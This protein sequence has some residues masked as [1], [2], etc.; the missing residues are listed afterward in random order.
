M[1]ERE[2]EKMQKSKRVKHKY[3]ANVYQ[4]ITLNQTICDAINQSINQYYTRVILTKMRGN[5]FRCC[6]NA[7]K[8]DPQN[9]KYY[10]FYKIFINIHQ[11]IHQKKKY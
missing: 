7:M 5:S 4:S 8:N 10:Y 3:S 1:K 6:S 9:I 2:R 11:N